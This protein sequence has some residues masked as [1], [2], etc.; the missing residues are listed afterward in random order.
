MNNNS[1]LQSV[2]KKLY[3]SFNLES[4]IFRRAL[5]SAIVV[6]LSVVIYQHF[7]LTQGYWVTLT[8]MIVVQATVGATLR[9][10]FQRFLGTL[11]GV[12]IASLLL[13][14]I[15]N[16]VIIDSLVILF[17]FFAYLVNPFNN[18][19]NYGLVVVP[20]SLAVVF[21]IALMTPDK[22]NAQIIFARFYDTVIGA[23][24]GVMGALI[25]FPNKV[26]HEF[27]ASKK[28]LEEQMM[29]YYD[30]IIDMIL[31][32]PN[33]KNRANT[34]KI[35]IET[36]LLSDRQYYLERRYEIH[37]QFESSKYEK[38]KKFLEKSEKIAQQL[39]SVHQI[40]R[41]FHLSEHVIMFKDYFIQFKNARNHWETFD[42]VMLAFQAQLTQLAKAGDNSEKYWH[43]IASMANLQFTLTNLVK[44]ISL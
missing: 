21:L 19:V 15:H 34:K 5:R 22:I 1:N 29:D 13:Y 40:A 36:A 32:V 26:K 23:I 9:R 8:A 42:D 20:M 41:H 12:I 18:L 33:A 16:R 11:L 31:N 35:L 37:F 30:A 44:T 43:D 7:S 4:L 28:Y 39:F 38:E 14:F 3:H 2:I 27:E 25:I 17:I 6:F 10:G 24:L